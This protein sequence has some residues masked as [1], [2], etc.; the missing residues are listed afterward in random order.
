MRLV[1]DAR[2]PDAVL[3][4][5]LGVPVAGHLGVLVDVG[6]AQEGR[7]LL[8][9]VAQHPRHDVVRGLGVEAV[10][11]L[12]DLAAAAD[13]V[14]L[15]RVLQ[16]R[17]GEQRPQVQPL[18]TIHGV[19]VP[20]GEPGA[21]QIDLAAL[22]VHA[23]VVLAVVG[24]LAGVHRG[25]ELGVQHRRVVDPR[26]QRDVLGHG[27]AAL[28]AR[29][30]VVL[31]QLQRRSGQAIAIRV[32]RT[33]GGVALRTFER[34][35][36][37]HAIF[38]AGQQFAEHAD[39]VLAPRRG[40]D[41]PLHFGPLHAV[42]EHRLVQ[43]V[44]DTQRGQQHAG[45]EIGPVP[46]QEVEVSELDRDRA[47]GA[48]RGM[49]ELQLGVQDDAVGELVAGVQHEAQVVGGVAVAAALVAHVLAVERLAVAA[50]RQPALD[51]V[52]LGRRGPQ[53]VHAVVHGERREV[54]QR[55][56]GAQLVHLL[57]QDVLLANLF[58]ARFFFFLLLGA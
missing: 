39:P 16:V 49:L 24:G 32:R 11:L 55:Q 53:A 31:F 13:L 1:A 25:A 40:D 33:R 20:D 10:H 12:G 52:D 58:G 50:D 42:E 46:H 48:G 35:H 29:A 7:Q 37:V 18:P 23:L 2:R 45:A 28:L 6:K 26:C 43:L 3:V 30:A 5:P 51:A 44:H 15:V 14:E 4:A 38:Q 19:Q 22:E 41:A 54:G 27:L 8:F 47:A 57:G 56:A 21:G 9:G 34:V 17:H 36:G